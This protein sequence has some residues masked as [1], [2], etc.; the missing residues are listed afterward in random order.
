MR[1]PSEILIPLPVHT[2]FAARDALQKG[3]FGDI[4]PTRYRSPWGVRIN[5]QSSRLDYYC[6]SATRL[7]LEIRTD[8][9]IFSVNREISD[10]EIETASHCSSL[11][12][13]LCG[14]GREMAMSLAPKLYEQ[15]PRI[16]M[17]FLGSDGWPECPLFDRPGGRDQST[18]NILRNFYREGV[19]LPA[20]YLGCSYC[21]KTQNPAWGGGNVGW[22][23]AGHIREWGV[24]P[25]R[26]R[27]L[28][29]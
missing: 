26:F 8:D 15:D 10:R 3:L 29:L 20:E 13:L 21:G 28:P 7:E 9:Q 18:R 12:W 25:H 19:R 4:D 24:E 23:C 22:I 11:L 14:I 16:G 5:M 1:P 17:L 2:N 27:A 6:L